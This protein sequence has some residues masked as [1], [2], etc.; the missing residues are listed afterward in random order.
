MGG[1]IGLRAVEGGNEFW[2]NLPLDPAGA[3]AITWSPPPPPRSEDR[4][5]R[6]MA[7][8]PARTR[9]LLVEDMAANQVITATM[10]RREGHMLD[11]A[12]SGAEALAM[13]QT[14]AYDVVLMDI[15]MPGMSGL[16]AAA[17]L[18]ALPDPIG[19]LPIIAVTANG[20][21]A[22]L[23]ACLRAG[24]ND[25]LAKPVSTEALQ[26]VL[27]RHVWLKQRPAPPVAPSVSGLD[28]DRI[29]ALRAGLPLAAFAALVESCLVDLQRLMPELRAA[30]TAGA[31]DEI[32]RLS[33]AIAGVAGSYGLADVQRRAGQIAQAARRGDE[34]GAA[35]TSMGLEDEME[36]SLAAMRA[37][38]L[39]QAA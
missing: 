31:T 39:A 15:S 20:S 13:V 2:V 4:A 3:G 18:R 30:L 16:E 10:L 26:N 21:S 5:M 9:I 29:D 37:Y 22:D 19:H 8:R 11:I 17:K 36:Q 7:R 12:R 38:M 34:L 23:D 33:H 35:K 28:L 1:K 6:G 32:G 24:M 25:L 27:L 14:T